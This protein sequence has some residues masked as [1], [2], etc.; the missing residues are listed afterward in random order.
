MSS[1]PSSPTPLPMRWAL[2]FVAASVVAILVGTFTFVQTMSWPVTLLT[3]LGSAGA[4]IQ[5]LH[6]VIG[7]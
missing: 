4:A 5:V 3:A 2:I 7:R 1:S 6:Q